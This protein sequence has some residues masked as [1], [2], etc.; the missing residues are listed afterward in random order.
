MRTLK[1]ALALLINAFIG[2]ATC[3]ALGAPAA[4]GAIGAPALAAAIGQYDASNLYAGVLVEVWTGEMIKKL[5]TADVA[6]FLDGLPDYSQYAENDL[7]HFVD[8]GADPDILVNNTTYPIAVQA[9]AD[10]DKVFQLDKFQTK[11]TPITDDEL[12]ALSY[13]KMAS[14]KERHG[15][16][17]LE[18]KYTKAIHALA[19]A[20]NSANTPVIETSGEAIDGRLRLRRQDMV[21]L[22]TKF[23]ALGVPVPGRRLVLCSEHVNDLLSQDQKF[24]EQYYHYTSG[25]ILNLFGFEIYEYQA[26]PYYTAAGNKKGYGVATGAEDRQASVAFYAPDMFKAM[27]STKMYFSEAKTDPTMQRNLINFRHYY[28]VLPKK[29]RCIGAILSA[30]AA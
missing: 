30:A 3:L 1:F 28:I 8:I 21:N 20:S 9:L 23:D 13:D 7:I 29:N 5:R 25:K 6:T 14:V 4:I 27:G 10:G 18:A 26:N 17:I 12:Y 16:A 22:K 19:P 15:K 2:V 11:A 24:A